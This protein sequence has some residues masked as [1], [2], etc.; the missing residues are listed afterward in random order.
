MLRRTAE[1]QAMRRV[2]GE[3]WE[4]RAFEL[5]KRDPKLKGW[6]VEKVDKVAERGIDIWLEPP[7]GCSARPEPGCKPPVRF[8]V[9]SVE[10]MFE[11]DDDPR[12]KPWYNR[13]SRWTLKMSELDERPP[14]YVLVAQD[15]VTGRTSIDVV[16][17]RR[18]MSWLETIKKTGKAPKLP[19]RALMGPH[20]LRATPCK[21][22]SVKAGT[23]Y[24]LE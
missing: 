5:I 4:L 1:A 7:D 20:G 18:V 8:E 16:D 15:D 2:S 12:S 19:V 23:P 22:V 21:L 24:H 3:K 14:C 13:L 17:S 10:K 6:K 9:K 11:R